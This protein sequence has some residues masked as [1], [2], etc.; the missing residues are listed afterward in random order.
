MRR[1]VIPVERTEGGTPEPNVQ[2]GG[3]VAVGLAF[4]CRTTLMVLVNRPA[5]MVI[6]P[7]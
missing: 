6:C 2:A 3:A 7:R 1:S 4:T 5:L